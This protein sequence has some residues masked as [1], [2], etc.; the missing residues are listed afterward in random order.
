MPR[1]KKNPVLIALGKN[2]SELRSTRN[3][4]RSITRRFKFGSGVY[5]DLRIAPNFYVII[6]RLFVPENL[7]GHGLHKNMLLALVCFADE[8]DVE[9]FMAVAPDRLEGEAVDAPRHNKVAD[10]LVLS[11][12]ELGFK[13][14]RDGEDV[15][16]LDLAYKPGSFRDKGNKTG[17]ICGGSLLASAHELAGAVF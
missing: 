4:L 6:D 11:A 8:S 15:Y 3:S 14:Y 13:P 12:M 10:A 7:R 5:C 1:M 16:R 2:V 17:D 9:L